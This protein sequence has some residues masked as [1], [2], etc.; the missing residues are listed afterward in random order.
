MCKQNVCIL[1]VLIC[2]GRQV[3]KAP[4][5]VYEEFD[6]SDLYVSTATAGPNVAEYEV[7]LLFFVR[8]K[9]IFYYSPFEAAHALSP[10]VGQIIEYEDY[11]NATD[12]YH[13]SEYEYE[14][15]Y[16]ERYGPAERQREDAVNALVPPEPPEVLR[17]AARASCSC[18]SSSFSSR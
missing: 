4:K 16:D 15:E 2:C 3:K 10:S 13:E 8:F 14:E 1:P 17:E 6:Y 18:V 5:K 9:K 11:D 7:R 12:P